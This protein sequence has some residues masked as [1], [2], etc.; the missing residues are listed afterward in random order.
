M[1]RRPLGRGRLLAVVAAVVILVGCVA[2]IE[3]PATALLPWFSIGGGPGELSLVQRGA[4]DGSGILAFLAAMAVLALVTLPYAA[5]DRPVGIDR[6]LVYL[7]ITAV[8][9]VGV[10]IWP[11]VGIDGAFGGLF[12]DRAPGYWIAVVGVIV[13]ARAT[14][15]IFQEPSRL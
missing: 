1:H 2:S 6:G 12:P 9:L 5:G 7:L 8:A 14:F 10:A 13:L 4:F 3:W 11:F 15:E